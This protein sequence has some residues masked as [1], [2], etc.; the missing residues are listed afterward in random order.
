MEFQTGHARWSGAICAAAA[1][2]ATGFL[3]AHEWKAY[4]SDPDAAPFADEEHL[5]YH[6]EWT[7]AIFREMA[8]VVGAMCLDTHDELV[9]AWRAV[10][11]AG[12]PPQ[13]MAKLSDMSLV[14]Y[15]RTRGTI[16]QAFNSKDKVDEVRIASELDAAFRR[17]YREAE[18]LARAGK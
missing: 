11:A 7:S 3:R 8:F 12:R 2:G 5:V 15:E 16:R 18:E 14:S 9:V 17:Q 6:P 1:A 10:N 13:A 4:R